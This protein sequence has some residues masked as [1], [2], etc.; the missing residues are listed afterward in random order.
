MPRTCL[1]ILGAS[2]VARGFPS[3][4]AHACRLWGE[5]LELF[6]AKGHGRSYGITSC[7]FG[8]TLPG[9]RE[10]HLFRALR[11]LGDRRLHALVTDIG[12]DLPYGVPVEQILAWIRDAFDE[13]IE[14]GAD[15][16]LLPMPIENLRAVPAWKYTAL[17]RTLYPRCRTTRTEMLAKSETL[18]AEVCAAARERGIRVLEHDSAWYG[19]DPIH[20]R[21]RQIAPA[22][23]QILR[24]VRNATCDINGST[25]GPSAPRWV[26]RLRPQRYGLFGR[27]FQ[28]PQPCGRLVDGTSIHLY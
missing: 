18:H 24:G 21:R 27:E 11:P 13:L 20:I 25:A 26:R 10:S 1:A 28:V 2:N 6:V 8:R 15:V 4:V 5:P 16:A 12:N 7:L 14:C 22:W 3:V 19:F 23:E 9:I 17:L